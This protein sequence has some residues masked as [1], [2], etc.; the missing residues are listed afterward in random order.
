M[1]HE[2]IDKLN[3]IDRYLMGKLLAEES[4]SFEDHFV[5]CPQCISDLRM[6]KNFMQDLRL[7]AAEQAFQID[8]P[9][10]KK[11]FGHFL[12]TLSGKP[13]AWAMSCLLIAAAI[14]A[15][16]VID[17]TRRLR[18]EV[19]QAENLSKQW[20]Q[21]YEAERESAILADS[22]HQETQLRQAE[23]LLALEA[24]L[25]EHSTKTEKERIRR[26]PS[27]GDRIFVLTSTRGGGPN[28]TE[29]VKR[30]AIP[31]SAEIF[32]FSIPLEEEQ[33]FESYRATI[34]RRGL[35]FNRRSLTLDKKTGS[36]YA[37][38]KRGFFRPGGYSLTIE[39]FK[40]ESEKAIIGSYP[41]SIINTP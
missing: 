21:R 14:G 7:V 1:R 24:K 27:E 8:R 23:Q 15:F 11:A 28:N 20:E 22:K 33:Q 17:Y 32:A 9:Q 4:A 39:G 34:Y 40:K 3:L 36:L 41:F 2:E 13:L 5:D 38:F 26:A 30:I 19:N 10:P 6:T 37:W 12:Q 25:K 29:A 35:V 18:A 16:F 31:R